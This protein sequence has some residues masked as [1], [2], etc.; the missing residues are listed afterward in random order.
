MVSAHIQATFRSVLLSF[1]IIY[2]RY[3]YTKTY[4]C[5]WQQ[6]KSTHN[7]QTILLCQ[8]HISR[9]NLHAVED[10]FLTVF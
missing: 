2:F 4:Y 8:C 9:R 5:H 3:N 1:S 6:V 7:S 10:T